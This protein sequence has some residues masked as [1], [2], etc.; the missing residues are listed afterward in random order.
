MRLVCV[1][2]IVARSHVLTLGLFPLKTTIANSIGAKVER[3]RDPYCRPGSEIFVQCA[4]GMHYLG[5]TSDTDTPGILR[6][7]NAPNRIPTRVVHFALCCSFKLD[8]NFNLRGNYLRRSKVSVGGALAPS[9]T[10]HQ[11]VPRTKKL[12]DTNSI[13]T[14][15]TL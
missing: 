5:R 11:G 13:L 14:L 2:T 6:I 1:K 12:P 4:P 3:R 10:C 8:F 15:N 9:E 7:R